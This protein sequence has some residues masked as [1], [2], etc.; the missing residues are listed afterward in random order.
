[1]ASDAAAPSL[2]IARIIY[3]VNWFN[4]AAI[5]PFIALEFNKDVSLLGSITAAF[6][7][8]VGLFQ[9]PA[10]IFAVKYSPRTSAIFGIATYSMASLLYA[11]AS[12]ASQLIWLRCVGRI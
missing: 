7:I 11:F 6:L 5:F 4:I 12:E 1:M 10:G 9:I 3:G 2:I 8:G